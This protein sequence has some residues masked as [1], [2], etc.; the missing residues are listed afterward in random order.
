MDEDRSIWHLSYFRLESWASLMP[1]GTKT[2]LLRVAPESPLCLESDDAGGPGQ[3]VASGCGSHH[4]GR[5]DP[6]HQD[7][8]GTR[9]PRGL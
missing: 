1:S 3:L 9:R 4:G 6:R 7:Q 5:Q 8:D 2:E